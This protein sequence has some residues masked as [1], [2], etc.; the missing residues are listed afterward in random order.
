MISRLAPSSRSR[1]SNVN[2]PRLLNKFGF[3]SSVFSNSKAHIIINGNGI[4]NSNGINLSLATT[5]RRMGGSN[6][7]SSDSNN[8]KSWYSTL[9]PDKYF[10][11]TQRGTWGLVAV[12]AG[13]QALYL[14]KKGGREKEEAVELRDERLKKKEE[15]RKEREKLGLASP[16]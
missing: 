5:T 6:S 2:T 16:E 9:F 12:V 8:N 4:G 11:L 1:V 7:N 15:R 14:Y 3:R 10:G 13:L